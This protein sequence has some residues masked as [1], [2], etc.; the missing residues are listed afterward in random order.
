MTAPGKFRTNLA[1]ILFARIA[2]DFGRLIPY[3]GSRGDRNAGGRTREI[4]S[5]DF[6]F[7]FSGTSTLLSDWSGR[8]RAQRFFGVPLKNE[9]R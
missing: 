4:I 1:R 8:E 2:Y 9:K 5:I 6:R 3:E 7:F